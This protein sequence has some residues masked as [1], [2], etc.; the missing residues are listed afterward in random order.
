VEFDKRLE[1]LNGLPSSPGLIDEVK[2]FKT[3]VDSAINEFDTFLNGPAADLIDAL[4]DLKDEEALSK[5]AIYV[6]QSDPPAGRIEKLTHIV[7]VDARL[8]ERCSDFKDASADKKGLCGAQEV[9]HFT[10]TG[11]EDPLWPWVE[12]S[13]RR[14]GTQNC[15]ELKERVGGVKARVTR[16]DEDS[17]MGRALTFA[18]GFPLWKFR[19]GNPMVPSG[20][21]KNLLSEME[22]SCA[23]FINPNKELGAD[24][25]FMIDSKNGDVQVNSPPGGS[26]K[27]GDNDCWDKIN[28]LLARGVSSET[29]AVY[30]LRRLGEADENFS[31]RFVE[32]D[33]TF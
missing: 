27:P 18:G 1:I 14:W 28:E 4:V 5:Q 23:K 2:A 13:S 29:C 17:D 10:M 32:C 6:W 21:T 26:A 3:A 11:S 9:P 30:F 12:M 19:F 24:G 22:S 31:I 20:G 16:F 25:A 15:W 33:N 7:R 8:P